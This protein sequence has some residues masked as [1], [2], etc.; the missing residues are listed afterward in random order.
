MKKTSIRCIFLVVINL[1]AFGANAQDVKIFV[2]LKGSDENEGTFRKPVAT[3][4]A[5]V[6]KA[7]NSPDKSVVQIFVREGEYYFTGKVSIS[8]KIIGRK[9]ILITNYKNEKV[10]FTG[11]VRLAGTDFLKVSDAA[12]LSRM[13]EEARAHVL[14]ADLKVKGINDFGKIIPHGFNRKTEPTPLELFYNGQP[15]TIAR[16]PNTGT[17]EIGQVLERGAKPNDSNPVGVKPVFKFDY[18]RAERWKQAK[19]ICISGMFTYGYADDN[20]PVGSIDFEAKTI[21]LSVPA[22]YPVYATNEDKT[23]NVAVNYATYQRRYFIYNLL[24]EID[25]PGEWYMDNESGKLYVYPP[26]DI[27]S[28]DIEVSVLKEPFLELRALSDVHIK[29]IDFKCSRSSGIE[30]ENLQSSSITDCDFYN[31][32]MVAVMMNERADA[33]YPNK[34]VA[35]SYCKAYHTGTGAFFLA[36][37]D[38]K[39]LT[40]G[41]ISIT[42]TE[43]HHFNRLNHTYSPAVNLGGVGNVIRHCFMYDATHLAIGFS[44]NDH[45]IEYNH[46]KDLCK[47]AS[48]MGVIY[49]GRNPSSRGTRISGNYFENIVADHGYSIAAVYI[50]DGS[51][52][53][54]VSNNIFYRAGSIGAHNFGAVNINGGHNNYFRDNIFIECERAFSYNQ[55]G[56]DNWIRNIN[57]R[58]YQARMFEEVNIYS[59]VYL[60]AYPELK[61]F[62]DVT[63]IEERK[64]F[65]FNTIVVG[66]GELS[67][68]TQFI[69]TDFIMSPINPGFVN[70][71][72]RDLRIIEG[73]RLQKELPGF[74][75]IDFRLIGI[76]K[77]AGKLH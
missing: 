4:Q 2:S 62:M 70:L 7:A 34:N 42:N 72:K 49:S 56:D 13:Q 14:V 54:K 30:I 64:N 23:D 1:F 77:R 46:F 47:S 18:E 44:G 36:G 69:N 58:L 51:G 59:D 33:P 31:L 29:G 66:G 24:E 45:V 39:S 43:I 67:R 40:P 76:Q 57:S 15:L 61:N 5:A 50:D 20:M 25:M 22:S 6:N 41:N 11:A 10:S 17:V 73:S 16:W 68:G 8:E 65:S 3:L 75:T 74:K 37:G 21:T 55:W 19:D 48:D 28:A 52:G 53:M 32:G 38:R 63:K 12:I 71:E 35:L 26:T 60:K 27:A 9:K